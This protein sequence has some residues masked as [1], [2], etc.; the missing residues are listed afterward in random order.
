MSLK[1]KYAKPQGVPLG[2]VSPVK[3]A[4]DCSGGSHPTGQ[5]VGGYD[6]Q[7]APVCRPGLVATYNCGTGTTNTEGNC[8]VGDAARGCYTGLNP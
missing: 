7:L 3:G 1:V 2:E 6:P 4:T 5:C 8:S